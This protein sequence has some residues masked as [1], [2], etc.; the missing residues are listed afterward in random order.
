MPIP[1]KQVLS[2]KHLL[3]RPIKFDVDSPIIDHFVSCVSD[4]VNESLQRYSL[5]RLQQKQDLSFR[6]AEL[7]EMV[8]KVFVHARLSLAVLLGALVYIERIRAEL[9]V[10]DDVWA[11]ERVFL[12]AVIAASKYLNDSVPSNKL[13]VHASEVFSIRDI[14]RIEREFLDVLDWKLEITEDDLHVQSTRL[15]S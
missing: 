5:D 12:G 1:L 15:V 6:R 3:I 11:L 13:W 10:K 4:V 7:R 2:S 8:F 14:N 9:M